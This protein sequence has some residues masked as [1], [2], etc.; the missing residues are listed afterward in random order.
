MT[1]DL[2]ERLKTIDIGT[3]TE[4]VQQDQGSST[5]MITEWSV[6]RLSNRG[7]M[8]PDGLWLF[9]GLGSDRDGLR[10]WSV[11]LKILER[12][13]EEGEDD[14]ADDIEDAINND[15]RPGEE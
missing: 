10:L 6:T 5:F 2:L 12:E 9:S 1:E 14:L 11:V 7:I 4:I 8:N 13:E 3:L 15:K